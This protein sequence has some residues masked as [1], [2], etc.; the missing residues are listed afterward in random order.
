MRIGIETFKGTAP[1]ISDRGLSDT[2]SVI[3][4]NARLRSGDLEPFQSPTSIQT[5]S[6]STGPT[7]KTVCKIYPID[8]TAENGGPYWLHWRID[9]SVNNSKLIHV[10]KAPVAGDTEERTLYTGAKNKGVVSPDSTNC[11]PKM[12]TKT[13]ATTV[14]GFSTGYPYD[15][16][17]LGVPAPNTAPV[18]T[19]KIKQDQTIFTAVA[20][21][22]L[23]KL[24]DCD[25]FSGFETFG[26]TGLDTV[27]FPTAFRVT[28][29]DTDV[30]SYV[31]KNFA[32]PSTGDCSVALS[33]NI[34]YQTY[35][36]GTTF[37][38]KYGCD[39]EGNGPFIDFST[40]SVSTLLMSHGTSSLWSDLTG[41]QGL[42]VPIPYVYTDVVNLKLS[43][44]Y[45]SDTDL[46]TAFV[47]IT[48]GGNTYS[49]NFSFSPIGTNFGI[50]AV[51]EPTTIFGGASIYVDQ[52]SISGLVPVNS[53]IATS[54]VETFINDFGQ[55]GSPSDPSG[56]VYIGPGI[57]TTVSG[58]YHPG[59]PDTDYGVVKYR[60]YRAASGSSGTQYQFAI[61]RDH[62][63]PNDSYEDIL[64]DS[65]LGEVL[66]TVGY[67]LPPK[68]GM[69]V[70]VMANGI[71]LMSS[72][73][74]L[75]PSVQY[76]PHAYPTA[77]KRSTD[78]DITGIVVLETSAIV[79]T[80]ESTYILTGSDPDSLTLS[81]LAS[82]HG[83]VSNR[84]MARWGEFGVIFATAE[85]LAIASPEGVRL[86]T[87]GFISKREWKTKF[88][89]T[90]I[91]GSVIEDKYFGYYIDQSNNR[92]GFIF[93][94]RSNSDGFVNLDAAVTSSY[95]DHY[96][97]I[98][99]YTDGRTLYSWDTQAPL[100]TYTWRSKVFQLP[101]AL[102]MS[103][104]QVYAVN[105]NGYVGTLTLNLY[106]NRST[107][108]F[109]TKVIT[110]S[111]E[112]RM[113]A[114]PC[115]EVQVELIGSVRVNRVQIAEQI[116]ELM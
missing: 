116:E 56:V 108:P 75:C 21:N 49:Y 79:T 18:V 60:L 115:E 113:P 34:P 7:D 10:A 74:Q 81:K 111:N 92:I 70:C 29:R 91:T 57:T 66:S 2:A 41:T 83:C 53:D 98:L 55:E 54:Y 17:Y 100:L 24:T 30:Y 8:K 112:F 82:T 99:F 69:N 67:D 109:F 51:R 95:S 15:W 97:E 68:D 61:E 94:P 25:S 6:K 90:T 3:C 96:N 71:T 46:Y 26:D 104:G 89:P 27:I 50:V 76:Q 13:L 106:K 65:E 31:A 102:S 11:W 114:I 64:L 19:Q 42:I 62:T 38:I 52:I 12:T 45:N 20:S 22:N 58:L 59:F 16:R 78:F 5:L 32:F 39:T 33:F 107:T 103:A 28:S 40:T 88:Y 37:R 85:G 1:G 63:V 36:N 43:S 47:D 4:Q 86:I 80:Q 105:Y 77:Y 110:D 48:I 73:N 84:S 23:V 35:V 9:E 101:Y 93:D 44:V 14:T 87:E 72:G